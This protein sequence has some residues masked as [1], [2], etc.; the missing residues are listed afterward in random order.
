MAYG[1]ANKDLIPLPPL[2]F[3]SPPYHTRNAYVDGTS[4]W[5]GMGLLHRTEMVGNPETFYCPSQT[6]SWLVH[7]TYVLDDGTWGM[8]PTDF[9]LRVGYQW[10]PYKDTNATSFAP[11]ERFVRYPEQKI[12]AMDV[13]L[14]APAHAHSD[15]N[16]WN[17]LFTAGHV[18]FKVDDEAKDLIYTSGAA[19]WPTFEPIV[20]LLE[21]P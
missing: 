6:A 13:A 1:S 14:S 2:W 12:L 8:P 18:T 5:Y 10:T 15:L 11:Y 20:E 7:E 3:S 21:R 19:L 16:G 17:R 4:R 9:Y